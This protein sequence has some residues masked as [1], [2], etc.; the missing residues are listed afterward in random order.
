MGEADDRVLT[1]TAAL[2]HVEADVVVGQLYD[3]TLRVMSETGYQS[4]L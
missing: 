4:F 2:L 3:C 1:E